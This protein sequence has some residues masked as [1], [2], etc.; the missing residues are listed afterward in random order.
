MKAIIFD[1]GGVLLHIDSTRA[2]RNIQSQIPNL[3]ERDIDAFFVSDVKNQYEMGHID[4]VT[5]FRQLRHHLGIN[6]EDSCLIRIWQDMFSE[7]KTLTRL[8][9]GLRKRYTL[10]I[11]S[12]TN[13]MHIDY[14]EKNFDFMKYFDFTFYSFKLG[15]LKPSPELYMKALDAMKIVPEECL[16]IDDSR[17]NIETARVMGMAGLLYREADGFYKN[18]KTIADL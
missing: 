6:T 18:L 12:N 14:I 1:L 5:F 10:A 13:E 15:Y 4:T 17:E 9:P 8:L 3:E 2:K 16:F 11:L 7:N